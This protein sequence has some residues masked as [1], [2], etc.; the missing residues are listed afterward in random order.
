MMFGLIVHT[1]VAR[2]CQ[3]VKFV[4]G[5]AGDCGGR[6][7]AADSERRFSYVG[8]SRRREAAPAPLPQTG[9]PANEEPCDD[10]C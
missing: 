1:M 7:V 4:S 5:S 2:V 8:A 3:L 10:A 6:N 9:D